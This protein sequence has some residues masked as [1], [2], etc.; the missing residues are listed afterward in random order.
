[1]EEQA[2]QTGKRSFSNSQ[3]F[4][5]V[6]LASGYNFEI[7][8]PFAEISTWVSHLR[9][10]VAPIMLASCSKEKRYRILSSLFFL[11]VLVFEV[12]CVDLILTS[13]HSFHFI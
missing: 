4:N 5:T 12:G 10:A 9:L 11:A 1:L 13:K 2:P 8:M 7:T 3:N 6:C